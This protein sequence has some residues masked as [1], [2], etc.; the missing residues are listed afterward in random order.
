MYLDKNNNGMFD[1]KDIG[2]ALFDPGSFKPQKRGDSLGPAEKYS[3]STIYCDEDFVK[4]LRFVFNVREVAAEDVFKAYDK[5]KNYL[6]DAEE[7]A[8]IIKDY[9]GIR[10]SKYEVTLLRNLIRSKFGR[11]EVKRVE[12]D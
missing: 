12:F 3:E 6:M 11:T 8:D 5:N 4:P 1:L 9:L 7:L 10:L 2:T